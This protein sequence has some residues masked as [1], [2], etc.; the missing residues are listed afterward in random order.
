MPNRT[1]SWPNYARTYANHINTLKV[2]H[3]KWNSPNYT[4]RGKTCPKVKNDV[5]CAKSGHIY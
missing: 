4:T 2:Y 1:K 5:K 3:N